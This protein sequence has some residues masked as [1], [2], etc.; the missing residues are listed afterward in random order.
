MHPDLPALEGSVL[1]QT[2][3]I[4]ILTGVVLMFLFPII[5]LIRE[6]ST[7]IILFMGRVLDPS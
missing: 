4:I 2:K 1:I 7:N 6:N 3:S 5:F